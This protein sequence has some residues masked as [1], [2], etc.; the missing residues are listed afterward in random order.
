MAVASTRREPVQSEQRASTA[1]LDVVGMG[2]E[3]RM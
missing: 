3:Q 1:D 2:P